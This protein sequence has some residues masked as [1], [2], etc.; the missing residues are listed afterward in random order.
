MV[1][2]LEKQ[3]LAEAMRT[4]R[5][6]QSIKD[7]AESP[8]TRQ[9]IQS[10]LSQI[11]DK[12]QSDI[13]PVAQEASSQAAKSAKTMNSTKTTNQSEATRSATIKS[14]MS[15]TTV[16]AKSHKI[17]KDLERAISI[18]ERGNSVIFIPN[19]LYSFI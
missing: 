18:A 15:A 13:M 19:D 6:L 10:L 8:T 1:M 12:T 16:S 2:L 9:R 17:E 14:M 3:R 5:Y 7:S 11:K 4:E